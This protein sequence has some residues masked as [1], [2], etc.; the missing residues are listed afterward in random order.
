LTPDN[1]EARL[2]LGDVYLQQGKPEDALTEYSRVLAAH[3]QNTPA[4]FRVADTNLR[5]GHFPEAVL[6]ASKV[7]SLDPRHRRARYVLATALVRAGQQEE[8]QREL[9]LYRKL[10][11]EARAEIDR[12]RDIIVLNRGAAAKL[13][14]GQP[15]EA[16][17]MFS[18]IIESYPDEPSHYL[19]LG[20]VHS[21]LG[22]HK[23]AVE[24]LQKMLSMGIGDSF[25]A[26][27]NLAQEYQLLGDV[28]ASRRHQVV[29]LQNLDVA[30]LEALDSNLD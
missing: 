23:A 26:Y 13:L 2:G 25:L 11:A 20:T 15:E 18:R 22:R 8:A 27:R 24:T 30:L 14:E 12:S 9:E 16:I 1:A 29:Y 7:V 10:E 4:Q 5:M 19:N 21:R 6:A 17:A 3:P 28:E